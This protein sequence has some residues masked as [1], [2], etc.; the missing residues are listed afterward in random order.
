MSLTEQ[1]RSQL[2]GIVQQ[3]TNNKEKESDIQWVVDDFKQKYDQP[4]PAAQP[5]APAALPTAQPQPTNE[6]EPS[7]RSAQNDGFVA[8]V[9]KTI[10][11]IPGSALNLG[12]NLYQIARHPLDTA[13]NIGAVGAGAI[14]AG[15][16][17]LFGQDQNVQKTQTQLENDQAFNSAKDYFVNR[18]GGMNKIKQ[19]I[20]NDPVGLAADAAT[21]L[22]GGGGLIKGAG[23]MTKINALSTA[24]KTI[25][26]VGET[27]NPIRQALPLAKKVVSGTGNFVKKTAN[28]ATAQ[29]TG[30]NPQTI[31]QI[32][33]TPGA[34]SAGEAAKLDRGT[35]ANQVKTAIDTRLADLSETG[36]LYQTI[37]ESGAAT[38]IPQGTLKSVL[39]KYGLK[40]DDA[41]KII[42]DRASVPM[43]PGDVSALQD[44]LDIYGKEGDL[45]ANEFLNTRKAAAAIADFDATKSDI[46]NKI[47]EDLYATLNDVARKNIDGLEALDNVYSPEVKILKK[48]KTDYL[49]PD[50]TLKDG[51][52]NKIANLTGKG[53]DRVI[54]RLEQIVPE[55][56]EQVNILKSIEDIEVTKGQKVGTYMRGAAGGFVAS[57]GNPAVAL[58]SGIVAQPA[59]IV[60]ILRAYGKV[61]GIFIDQS[62]AIISK[63]NAGKKLL[64]NEQAFFVRAIKQFGPGFLNT[65]GSVN[66]QTKK[67]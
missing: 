32:I 7:F 50:G 25:S 58:I 15:A 14:Q 13:K 5:A 38:S 51:A 4:L 47:G 30:L 62:E 33:K 23:K 2:D 45:N 28:F 31:S 19:T 46:A 55:I 26:K 18:F 11:N 60:P 10:G 16:D 54:A 41:G 8:S 43:K 48:I 56:R 21:V 64:P 66:A 57:G 24:G 44:F 37:R 52:M 67:E 34:F 27:I 12:K 63:I 29:S 22:E 65:V 49:N 1:R 6:Y 36:S 17:S 53:K 59:A 9:G 20:I 61:S 40:L 3:M 35:L 42:R 39:S